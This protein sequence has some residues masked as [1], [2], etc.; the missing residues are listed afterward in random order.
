MI[1]GCR[2]RDCT[3]GWRG[4]DLFLHQTG[5]AAVPFLAAGFFDGILPA[6]QEKPA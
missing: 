6:N 4:S 3:L 5:R 2:S 1:S